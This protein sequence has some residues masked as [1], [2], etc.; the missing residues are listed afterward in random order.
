MPDTGLRKLEVTVG[1][2]IEYSGIGSLPEANS[3]A[4]ISK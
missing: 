4:S 1:K 3:T 2:L